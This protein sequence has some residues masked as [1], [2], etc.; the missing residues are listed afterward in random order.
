MGAPHIVPHREFT[1][2][3]HHTWTL[4]YSRQFPLRDR[5]IVPEFSEGIRALGFTAER[6]PDLHDVNRR[7][8]ALTG[9]AGVPV[10]GFEE[11]HSF[12][13]ML[14]RREFPIG[15][16]IRDPKDLGYTPAPDVFHDLYGHLPF[17]TDRRYADFCQDLGRRTMK[18]ADD[19]ELL[20]Q[21]ERLFWY[22]VEFPL[23]DTSEGRRIFGA[24]IASSFNEC[25]YA[26]SGE[27][28]VLAFD[29]EAVRR[30]D[31]EID[32]MQE[33]VFLLQSREELYGCLDA[34]ERGCGPLGEALRSEGTLRG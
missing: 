20:R 7:L 5:Q 3:E 18:F 21:W 19:A 12:Y 14:A 10:E 1:P 25:A 30:Q 11:P 24:G 32:R 34:F 27:P 2:A 26:L 17:L 23:L 16:F 9:F 8:R 33:S 31:F 28:N 13:E 22:G 4:L 6:I 15:Y 29:V